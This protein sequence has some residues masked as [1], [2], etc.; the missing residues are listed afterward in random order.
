[1]VQHETAGHIN[2][3]HIFDTLWAA[4]EPVLVEPFIA[5]AAIRFYKTETGTHHFNFVV[6]EESGKILVSSTEVV[7]IGSLTFDSTVYWLESR[8]GRTGLRFGA[9]SFSI[10][11]SDK[12]LS[13]IPLYIVKGNRA[14][15]RFA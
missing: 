1:M 4:G 2:I 10:E 11:S 14:L 12:P 7:S 8:M 15:Q 13:S 3:L 9:Y 5:L 6:R